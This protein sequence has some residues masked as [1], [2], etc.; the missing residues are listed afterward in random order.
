MAMFLRFRK[1]GSEDM[2]LVN[3][4]HVLRIEPGGSD[5][6]AGS[7]SR[8]LHLAAASGSSAASAIETEVT[9]SFEELSS[10]LAGVWEKDTSLG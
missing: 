7:W 2:V 8:L 3:M 9:M 10:V 5:G 4:D 6:D 1:R